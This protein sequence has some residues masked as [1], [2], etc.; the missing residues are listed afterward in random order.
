[1]QVKAVFLRRIQILQ[2]SWLILVI[3]VMYGA[4][5]VHPL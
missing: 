2:G 4:R 1:M 3:N 5:P